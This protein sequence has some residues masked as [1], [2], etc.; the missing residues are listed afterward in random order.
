MEVNSCKT[1][2]QEQLGVE[3]NNTVGPLE[4]LDFRVFFFNGL[5]AG[6]ILKSKKSVTV[7]VWVDRTQNF[8]S[9]SRT[10]PGSDARIF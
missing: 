6:E 3:Q 4:L 2:K 8:D 1:L 5:T 9:A 7:V 10:E